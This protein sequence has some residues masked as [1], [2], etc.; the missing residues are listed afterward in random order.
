MTVPRKK[1]ND[2]REKSKLG[3][4]FG[5]FLAIGSRVEPRARSRGVEREIIFLFTPRRRKV[6]KDLPASEPEG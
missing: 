4:C 2:E 6:E 5:F 1:K 3:A